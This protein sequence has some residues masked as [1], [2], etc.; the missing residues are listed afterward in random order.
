M[1]SLIR[2]M[3]IVLALGTAPAMA[4]EAASGSAADDTTATEA[5]NINTADAAT[6]AEH[7][8]GVGS[9]K[10]EAIVSFR[11]ENGPFASAQEL[12]NVTGIGPKTVDANQA[13]MVA[14]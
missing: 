11:E 12:T 4:N 10:A 6:L 9:V 3:L 13:G 1:T 8:D 7:L 5:I 2:A 14:Q